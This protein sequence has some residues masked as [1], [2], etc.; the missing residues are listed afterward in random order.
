MATNYNLLQHYCCPFSRRA[1]YT[2][3]LRKLETQIT[4]IDLSDKPQILWDTN[5]NGG[6]PGL[7]V[8]EAG[9]EH[10]IFDS[11]VIVEVFDSKGT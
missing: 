6:T 8:D 3:K 5:P 4:E 2:A 1:L 9:A 11:M 10:R 7:I